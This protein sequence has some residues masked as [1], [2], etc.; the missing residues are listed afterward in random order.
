MKI[1]QVTPQQKFDNLIEVLSKCI[2][3]YEAKPGGNYKPTKF[4]IRIFKNGTY[5]TTVKTQ[6]AV[7]KLIN[8]S[9]AAVSKY[10]SELSLNG[11][12]SDD[13]YI[14]KLGYELVV[15][16]EKYGKVRQFN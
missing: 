14:K 7:C 11:K 2:K 12:V 5:V 10:I 3:N 1:L 8:V 4:P 15:E 9:N 6:T 13:N 16:D